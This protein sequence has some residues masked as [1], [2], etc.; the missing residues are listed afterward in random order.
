MRTDVEVQVNLGSRCKVTEVVFLASPV[1]PPEAG[2]LP[3]FVYITFLVKFWMYRW[4]FS[5]CENNED[6]FVACR[7]A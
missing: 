1:R 2:A 4:L 5:H 7:L 3:A 6:S